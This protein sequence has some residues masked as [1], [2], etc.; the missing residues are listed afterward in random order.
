[1]LLGKQAT[2]QL[3]RR[4]IRARVHL[5]GNG[6]LDNVLLVVDAH[7]DVGQAFGLNALIREQQANLLGAKFE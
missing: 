7:L 6:D 4:G 1:V 5:I 2:D 3:G